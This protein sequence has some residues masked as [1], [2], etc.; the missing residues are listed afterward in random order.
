MCF[1]SDGGNSPRSC[2]NSFQLS[3]TT[4]SP[5]LLVNDRFDIGCLLFLVHVKTEIHLYEMSSIS[6]EPTLKTQLPTF[7]APVACYQGP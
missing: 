1:L 3:P 7:C 4:S 5:P 2:F 6:E